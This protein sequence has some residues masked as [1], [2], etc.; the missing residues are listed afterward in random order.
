M[1]SDFIC[2]RVAPSR[3]MPSPGP[4]HCESLDFD[5]F[6]VSDHVVVSAAID[7]AYLIRMGSWAVP[8]RMP[9]D[10]GYLGFLAR[11]NTIRLFTR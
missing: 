3:Q 8:R 11:R 4:P 7:S 10:A 9:G 2:S 6:G 5:Y 1:K